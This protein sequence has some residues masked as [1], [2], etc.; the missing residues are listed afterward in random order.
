MV[1]NMQNLAG[2]LTRLGLRS[3]RGAHDWG[4]HEPAS[5]LVDGS[6]GDND[7][8]LL[9][10]FSLLGLVSIGLI[11]IVTSVLLSRF[12]EEHLL[13]RDAVVMQEF[14]ERIAQHHDPRGYFTTTYSPKDDELNDFFKDIVHMPDVARINAYSRSGTVLWSS[15]SSLVGREFGTND[16]LKEALA[17]DL[18]Y[19]KG[20]I[21]KTEKAE[22]I[23]FNRTVH[24]FVENYIPIRDPAT[25]VIVGV[26]EIYRIPVALAKSIADGRKLVWSSIILG[27]IFLYLSLF[28][29]VRRAHRL[30]HLQHQ[31]LLGQTRLATIGEMASSVAHSIRNPIA[32]IRTS[33]ELALEDEQESATAESLRDI[34]G[35]VDRFDGW[36]R[37]LLSFAKERG[38]PKAEA[39]LAAVIADSVESFRTRAARQG[40]EI[41]TAIQETLP[42]V[43]GEARLLVQVVNSLIANALD[44]MPQGGKLTLNAAHSGSSACLTISDNGFGIPSDKLEGLFDPLVSHKR[45]GLGIGLALARQIVERYQGRIS[46][47]SQQGLGTTVT[48]ELPFGTSSE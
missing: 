42:V 1:M 34:I 24:W 48:I 21:S 33:A 20:K 11:C 5:H 16:E 30:I 45:G 39:D 41:L 25:D 8:N 6:V 2:V 32:S 18:V 44:A 31:T 36:I 40:V 19:E 27:G 15:D 46:I 23:S 17:G 37:E 7:F 3:V 14:V 12:L 43:S 10:S 47:D 38:D 28:W 35:E 29:I 4:Q 22:H 9:T 26:V 13:R